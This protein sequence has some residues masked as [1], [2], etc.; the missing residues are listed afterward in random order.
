[1]P[2]LLVPYKP[3]LLCCLEFC[4]QLW[5]NDVFKLIGRDGDLIAVCV[6]LN[7]LEVAAMEL[8]IKEIVI[9]LGHSQLCQLMYRDSDLEP[10][11]D[12]DTRFPAF[13]FIRL[14]KLF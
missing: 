2:A 11:I 5:A 13:Q 9:K 8:S 10:A 4:P 12:C 3:L 14:P 6:H 1:M 7:Q